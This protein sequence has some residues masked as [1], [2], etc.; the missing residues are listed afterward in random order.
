[1]KRLKPKTIKNYKCNQLVRHLD[2][3]LDLCEDSAPYRVDQYGI[4]SL[5]QFNLSSSRHQAY[6]YHCSLNNRDAIIDAIRHLYLKLG[7]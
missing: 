6:C 2:R 1:M 3:L 4:Y 5:S 7:L